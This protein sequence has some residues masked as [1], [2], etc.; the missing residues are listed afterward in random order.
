MHAILFYYL[1]QIVENKERILP[2]TASFIL[3]KTAKKFKI[4]S[5]SIDLNVVHGMTTVARPHEEIKH[6]NIYTFADQC[7]EVEQ[8]YCIQQ[9]CNEIIQAKSQDGWVYQTS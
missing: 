2:L 3:H 4:I 5:Y 6:I 9:N 1:K 8:V 7:W